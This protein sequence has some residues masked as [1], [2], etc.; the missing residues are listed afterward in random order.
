MHATQQRET[1]TT[2]QDTRCP[3]CDYDQQGEIA[4]WESA[5]PQCCPLIGRCTE[6]GL[7]FQWRLVMRPE[8]QVPSWFVEF[9]EWRR[10]FRASILTG[11]MSAMPW[12]F[13]RRVR[14]EHPIRWAR[15]LCTVSVLI[16]SAI[17]LTHL[18]SQDRSPIVAELLNLVLD[19]FDGQT[20]MGITLEPSFGV[21]L[22]TRALHQMWPYGI[23]SITQFLSTTDVVVLLSGVLMP[24]MFLLLPVTLRQCR[25][26]PS[27]VLRVM[28]YV[29]PW[30]MLV[31][32]PLMS[33]V[34]R[35]LNALNWKFGGS[36]PI[37]LG[38]IV[39]T[40]DERLAI[41][42]IPACG[43]WLLL[44]WGFACA[45]YLRLPR[46]WAV[47]ASLAAISTMASVLIVIIVQPSSLID[48]FAGVI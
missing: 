16:F 28:L 43:V 26:R 13:W 9:A 15:L 25:V 23:P 39:T 41:V 22:N 18:A 37:D 17:I 27:H 14:M 30:I 5:V 33:V 8:L 6:C 45:R 3:R 7:D 10:I 11:L 35:V 12:I 19:Q 40:F 21:R 42:V 38:W 47:A 31:S 44:G 32:N 46:P 34:A 20:F 4:R 29:T 36:L 24:A 2:A 48:L 1:M